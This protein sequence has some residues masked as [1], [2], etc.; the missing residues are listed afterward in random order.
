MLFFKIFGEV[1]DYFR[2]D[3]VCFDFIIYYRWLNGV[4]CFCCGNSM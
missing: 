3:E 1:I 2:I 4:V